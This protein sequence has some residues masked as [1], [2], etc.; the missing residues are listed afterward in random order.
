MKVTKTI[1]LS[2]WIFLVFMLS[3]ARAGVVDQMKNL[4]IQDFLVQATTNDMF[5][6]EILI[7]EL[8]LQ[9]QKD[10]DL[11]AGDL[12]LSVKQQYE[13][14][15]SQDRNEPDTTVSLSKLFPYQGTQLDV[16]YSVGSSL[17]S[18]AVKSDLLISLSQPIAKNAFGKS[19]QLHSKIIG[20]EN[21]VARHQIVE[22]YEDYLAAVITAYYDWYE[23]YENLN[24][25]K[26]S[27]EENLKLLDNINARA[28]SSIALPID[29][30]KI[31]LQVMAK[32]EKLV[33]LEEE[34]RNAYNVVQRMI[35]S[36]D[37]N[38]IIPI[39]PDFYKEVD[40]SFQ[41][42]YAKFKDESRTYDVLDLLEEKSSL[43]VDK[44]A[45]DLLP[46]LNLIVGYEVKGD[47]YDIEKDDNFLFAGVEFEWPIGHQVD[48]AEYE[49]SKI[50]HDKQ[51][52]SNLNTHYALYTSIKNLSEWIHRE[53]KLK[54]IA[55]KKISLAKDI[56]EDETENFS[57]GKVS[58]NDYISA[59]NV[60]DNNRFNQIEHE[61]QSKRFIVEW[62]RITDQLILAQ[63]ILVNTRNK[64]RK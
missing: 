47:K 46:S 41:R 19:T 9:Y 28:K 54:S 34:Y 51:K 1:K 3:A 39:R 52:L 60:L 55:D 44:E 31:R 29:V 25:A 17:A 59:V 63:D 40:I 4:T 27:Y 64:E 24:I 22:A 56:L 35:R 36:D 49:I 21:D 14:Y 37:K 42:D 11:P 58:L 16:D 8:A 7:D 48:Q 61:V 2:L 12:V 10:L 45:D 13:F 50:D 26:S 23:S 15:F 53:L 57:F 30:N 32:E 20:L 38:D 43:E 5:F 62:L 6:E 18:S 33:E